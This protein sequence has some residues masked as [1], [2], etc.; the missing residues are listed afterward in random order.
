MP[1]CAVSLID[2][3]EQR[4]K[5]IQ[6]VDLTGTSREVAFCDHMIRTR[7]PLVVPDAQADPR[8][9]D[10][11]LVTGEPH[12]QAYAGAPLTT[13]DGYNVSA[14]CAMHSPR[15]RNALCRQTGRT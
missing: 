14:L 12:I 4:F 10:N 1:I 11:P 5:S 2:S 8:F 6:G 15:R 9:A 7:E 13:P 3:E